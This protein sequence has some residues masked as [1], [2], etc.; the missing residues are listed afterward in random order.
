M[1]ALPL[2]GIVLLRRAE[3]RGSWPRATARWWTRFCTTRISHIPTR[4]RERSWWTRT[5]CSKRKASTLRS[6]SSTTL[7]PTPMGRTARSGHSRQTVMCSK[8]TSREAS[9]RWFVATRRCTSSQAARQAATPPPTMGWRP[10]MRERALFTTPTWTPSSRPSRMGRRWCTT[11]TRAA[12]R[13]GTRSG[14]WKTPAAT[15]TPSPT[16]RAPRRTS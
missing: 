9:P 5:F 7:A 2:L 4:F 16:G 13:F 8:T 1:R 14:G 10:S 15:A 6:T 11:R 12:S 3:R